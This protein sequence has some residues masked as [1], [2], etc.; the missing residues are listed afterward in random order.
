MRSPM[1]PSLLG[2]ALLAMAGVAAAASPAADTPLPAW[3][4]L[5]PAQREQL[6]APIRDRWNAEPEQRRRLLL[7]AQ[8]WQTLSPDQRKRARHGVKRWQQMDPG[9]R[10]QMRAVFDHLRAMPEP[11]RA[12]FMRKWRAMSAE[13]KRAWLQAHPAPA[14][15]TRVRQRPD[16]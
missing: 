16:R 13:Q 14:E 12:V 9:H 6:I 10:E 7:H 5:T 1:T 4:Q 2:I 11:E 8:R 3:E 15:R